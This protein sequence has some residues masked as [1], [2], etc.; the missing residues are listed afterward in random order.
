[1]LLGRKYFTYHGFTCGCYHELSQ[2]T[3]GTNGFLPDEHWS[4][5]IS[6]NS[7]S[8]SKF[9]VPRVDH[10]PV[11]CMCYLSPRKENI[12]KEENARTEPETNE[13]KFFQF[14][15]ESH[16]KHSSLNTKGKGKWDTTFSGN[17]YRISANLSAITSTE[18]LYFTNCSWQNN[19]G[20]KISTR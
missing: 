6:P 16:S 19:G 5:Q 20:L 17:L 8:T 11:H 12:R 13:R 3:K 1:M 14:P 7:C 2:K 4:L 9:Y 18:I 10:F 15:I